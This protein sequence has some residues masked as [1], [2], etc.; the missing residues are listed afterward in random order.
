VGEAKESKSGEFRQER[1]PD[2][3]FKS[4]SGGLAGNT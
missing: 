3:A 2:G 4:A 1:V